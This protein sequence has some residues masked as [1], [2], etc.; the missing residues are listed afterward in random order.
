MTSTI[1]EFETRLEF[2]GMHV[3]KLEHTK[4]LAKICTKEQ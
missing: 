3:L 1:F 2:L 4:V